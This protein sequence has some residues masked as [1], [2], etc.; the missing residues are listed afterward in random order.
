MTTSQAATHFDTSP[1]HIRRLLAQYRQHGLKGLEPKS[2]KPHHNPNATNQQTINQIIKLRHKLQN[3]GLDN[4][5]QSI[6]NHLP[7]K[8]RPSPTTIWRILKK[9][10]PN[11]TPT[12]KTTQKLLPPIP[13]RPT[14]PNLAI[15]LHPRPTKKRHRHT[16]NHLARRPLPLPPTRK[17]PPPHHLPNRSP[18]LHPNRQNPRPTSLNPHR[19]RNGL[20]HPTS[21]RKQHPQQ[22]T[23]RLRTTTRRTKHH[24]KKRSPSTPHH[25]RKN[26]TLPPNPQKM[27]QRPTTSNQPQRPKHTPKRLPTHLQHQ[28]PPQSTQ[29]K[30]TP[31][32]LPQQ[33]KS[34]PHNHHQQKRLARTTRHR[35]PK[36]HHNP[37]IPRK[38]HP[39]RH[40]TRPQKQPRNRP[41]TRT[42][43]HNHQQKHRGNH[44]RTHHQPQQ[45][46][47]T[48]KRTNVLKHPKNP[49]RTNDPKHP[50][51][52]PKKSRDICGHMSRDIIAVAV[53]FE[54]TVGCPTQHFECCTF[55]RSDTLPG[56]SIQLLVWLLAAE[57]TEG[58]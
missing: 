46:L 54:P 47:P 53:G 16:S 42:T 9:S 31:P 15:R 45:N 39:P 27:A 52:K 49:K 36:R 37:Q 14:Q 24:P 57:G 20:H 6:W 26:R 19:Q 38:T 55:G 33:T 25:P 8:N 17:R 4:G 10:Q 51:Q 50:P 7:N 22:P 44:R 11:N 30:N 12:P 21:K 23:Q 48:K 5:P 56:N 40:R 58:T 43:H 35:R 34:T 3:E 2:R 41:N 29:Q 28:T 18:N 13:S 32:G 1:R